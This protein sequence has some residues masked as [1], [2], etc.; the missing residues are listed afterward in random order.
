M[1]PALQVKRR[2]IMS[3][4]KAHVL[5]PACFRGLK[6]PAPSNGMFASDFSLLLKNGLYY[7]LGR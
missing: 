5:E 1:F 3:G 2:W 4:A 7:L 6:A